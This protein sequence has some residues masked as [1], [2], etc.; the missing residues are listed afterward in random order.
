M[1]ARTV[2]LA[3]GM[4]LLLGCGA[5]SLGSCATPPREGAEAH[6]ERGLTVA[7]EPSPPDSPAAHL[8]RRAVI[9]GIDQYTTGL[10]PTQRGRARRRALARAVS[11][12]EAIAALLLHQYDFEPAGVTVLLD[13]A[14]TRQAILDALERTL[15]ADARTDD[16]VVF[17]YA[18]HGSQVPNPASDEPDKL[19]ESLVPADSNEGA[20][21]LRDKELARVF[22]RILDRGARLTVILDSCYSGSL[23]RGLPSP[24]QPRFLPVATR[25]VLD[26]APTGGRPE[27]RGAL[28][29]SAAQDFELAL[30]VRD[31]S[32]APHGAFSLALVEAMRRSLAGEPAEDTFLRARGLLQ[33]SDVFQQPV[34]AGT[35]ERRRAP[36]FGSG[37]SRRAVG[38]VVAVQRVEPSGSVLLQ[39]GWAHGLRK[40]AELE[41]REHAAGEPIRLRVTRVLG[42]A[43]AEAKIV[44]TR[45]AG[46]SRRQLASGDL[47]TLSSWALADQ[48]GLRV[49]IPDA[50]GHWQQALSLARELRQLAAGSGVTWLADPVESTPTHVA[51]WDGGWW[52][53]PRGE[54]SRWLGAAPRPGDV[55]REVRND[56][57]K[58]ASLFVQL[59][60]PPALGTALELGAGSE[61]DAVERAPTRDGA[62]YQL[63]GR[64]AGDEVDFAWMRP[65]A[66]AADAATSPLPVRSDWCSGEQ[67]NCSAMLTDVALRL[68]KIRSWLAV[69][70]PPGAE[71]PYRLW[72]VD[73]A[74]GAQRAGRLRAGEAYRLIARSAGS[75][76]PFAVAPRYLY[77][78][79]IDSF[80]TTTLLFP[81]AA[82]GSVENRFPVS[83]ASDD[84]SAG[85]IPLGAQPAFRVVAP[86]GIDSFFLLSSEE[87]IPN[88]WVVQSTGVRSRGPRG[89]T[90]LED[91]LSQIGSAARGVSPERLPVHWSLEQL[92]FET[93][94]P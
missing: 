92:T 41:V 3:L 90:R 87:P 10:T 6:R 54:R 72:L 86:F 75:P 50:A 7:R 1:M 29:L 81:R 60:V 69:E 5:N 40:G 89:T 26:A 20:E 66:G 37:D 56:A 44:E 39:G 68:N 57:G 25:G 23:A 73:E 77:V 32:G 47:A 62:H 84:G 2:P 71:F 46:G 61:N 67:R 31:G 36:L 80:G 22:N 63:V 74:G 19:D 38:L 14:A 28:I 8:R 18:G 91:L 55:L 85:E 43:T 49:W 48:P 82:Q 33:A 24:G 52:L 78:F 30:E 13:R 79:T 65:A 34:L 88:P 64:L 27:E 58:P 51:H 53:T 35:A 76:G 42:P 45:E 94:G 70:S 11:D 16:E 59:P 4:L 15:A 9:V 12:A 93:V 83:T 21:D 17:V